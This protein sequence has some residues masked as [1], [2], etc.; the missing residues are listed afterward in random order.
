MRLF[1]FILIFISRQASA[2]E[3]K[4]LIRL[5]DKI[6]NGYNL[7][8]P[9]A[10][11]SEKSIQRR[12]KQNIGLEFTDLP[13]T[14]AYIDSISTVAYTRIINKS[15]WFNQLLI[16]TTDTTILARIRSFS[17]VLSLEPV[18]NRHAIKIQER[19]SINYK[20]HIS[21][22]STRESK[23]NP[24]GILSP[25]YYGSSFN[26]INIHHGDFLHEM[27]FRGEAMTIA[28]L[29][30]GFNNYLYNPAFEILRNEQHILGT[31]DF[32]NGKVSV[33][34]EGAH[35][36]NCFSII[37]SNLPT[38]MIGSAPS[39]N[40]WLFKSEDDKS[41]TPVE[42]QNW[43]AAA[44]FADSVGVDLITTSLGYGY[45]DDTAYN[46]N[47]EKRNGHT[48]LV[49][50]AANLAVSKGMIVTASM[51][52]SGNDTGDKIYVG[53]PADGDSV[54]AVGAVKYDGLLATFSSRGPN[55]SGQI[56]PD[57]VSVGSGTSLI[58]TDGNLYSGDGTSYSTPNLAGLITCLW[59]A[60]P[61]FNCH[62]ILQAVRQ[63]SDQYK[64]PDGRYGYGLPDFEKAYHLLQIKR[65]GVTVQLTAS[66][67]IHIY[68]NPFNKT[69][70]IFFRPTVTGTSNIELL[71]VSGKKIQTQ[72]FTVAT[73][74][75]QIIELSIKTALPAGVYL[76]RYVDQKQS[77]TL[78][79]LKY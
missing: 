58:G 27:G 60:F 18:N 39:A 28:I 49:S 70:T 17:F 74:E 38:V 3:Y 50:R 5:K 52:N 75:D 26:Q 71:D 22:S 8:N 10:F 37:A 16:G 47:Y 15:R 32:V 11:L 77:K 79:V 30:D 67:W 41:E 1:L 13:L 44:E 69:I 34:E 72:S 46:L 33:N 4:Y 23:N 21:A 43:V 9:S 29:D 6:N 56:K 64:N 66:D 53:C 61:E 73:N 42:E 55:N 62:D 76:I 36:S 20:E 24:S 54:Y 57:G 48:A 59:Q 19:V 65:L 2:Q 78:K 51:G 45:F 35:G 68:P 25:Y 7:A 14:Q 63:S 31:Y 12:T 40:Y